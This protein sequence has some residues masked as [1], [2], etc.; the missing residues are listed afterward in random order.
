MRMI[1]KVEYA[2]CLTLHIGKVDT[3]VDIHSSIDIELAI[4]VDKILDVNVESI[5]AFTPLPGPSAKTTM[6]APSLS[7]AVFAVGP[8]V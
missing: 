4:I 5:E 7:V 6:E 1:V 3:I 2:S 8:F